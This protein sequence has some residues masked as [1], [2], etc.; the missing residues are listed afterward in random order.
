MSITTDHIIQRIR[1][2]RKSKRFS[3][4][5]CATILGYPKK[6]YHSIEEGTTPLSLPELELLALYFGVSPALFFNDDQLPI[7]PLL[8]KED[9]RPHY[10]NLRG[11]MIQAMLAGAQDRKG[12]SLK[13]IEEATDIPG[14]VLKAYN[15]GDCPIPLQDLL[16]IIDFLD[17]PLDALI[18]PVWEADNIPEKISTNDDWQP[19]FV[20]TETNEIQ[21]EEDPYQDMLAAFRSLPKTDQ[22]QIAKILLDKLKSS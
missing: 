14:D 21:V 17:I 22:A 16:Q 6:T 13:D 11:K 18:E 8:L 9:I 10:L 19:E 12:Y 7:Y 2:I 4:H 15:N 20:E 5:D 1:Q 3:I